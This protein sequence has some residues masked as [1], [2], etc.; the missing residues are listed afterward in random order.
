MY[1]RGQNAGGDAIRAGLDAQQDMRVGSRG[2]RIAT[3]AFRLILAMPL[4]IACGC[5]GEIPKVKASSTAKR[6]VMLPGVEG[7]GWQLAQMTKGLRDAGIE[8]EIEIIPWGRYPF[9]TLSNLMNIQ[10]NREQAEAIAAHLVEI[11]ALQPNSEITLLGYSGGGGIAVMS[12]E[13]LPPDV[14]ISRLILVAAALSPRYDL[15]AAAAHTDDG[16]TS[17]YSPHDDFFLNLGTGLFGTIDRVHTRAAGRDG[18]QDEDGSLLSNDRVHQIAWR[19]EWFALGHWGGHLGW[20]AKGWAREV[21]AEELKGRTPCEPDHV[22]ASG[23]R[24]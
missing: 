2:R 6:L 11:K 1:G 22:A 24:E 15:S 4:L 8:H 17:Y 19:K 20:L 23:A 12:V 16:I 3:A 21:L 14:R 13:N 18:F 7:S 9:G 10:R 5:A